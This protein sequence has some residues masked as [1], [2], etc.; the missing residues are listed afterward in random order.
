MKRNQRMLFPFQGFDPI[1]G[2][3][4]TFTLIGHTTLGRT[5]LAEDQSDAE[6]LPDKAQCSQETKFHALVG[7]HKPTPFTVV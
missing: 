7:G 1:Q 5:N 3:D 4:P 2:H 6:T